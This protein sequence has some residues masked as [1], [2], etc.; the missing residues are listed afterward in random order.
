MIRRFSAPDC[1]FLV[2]PMP[3]DELVDIGHEALIR[4]WGKIANPGTGWLQKESA[5]V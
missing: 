3:P 2:P 5:M 1:S 4:Q